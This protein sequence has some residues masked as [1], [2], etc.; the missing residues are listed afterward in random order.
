MAWRSLTLSNG[1]RDGVERDVPERVRDRHADD[2]DLALLDHLV[3]IL[4]R[5]PGRDVGVA[6]LE[7]G[8]ARPGRGDVAGDHPPD[9]RQRPAFPVV[10]AREDGLASGPP[11]L[12]AIGAA[13]GLVVAQ[14]GH[15]PRI[16]GGGILFGER[17]IDDERHHH[18]EIEHQ[19]LVLADE[20]D[21]K[22]LVVDRHEL[23]GLLEAAGR[24][25]EG[26]KAADRHRAVERPFHV[27]GGHRRAVVEGRVLA[28]LE[29]ARHAVRGDLPAFRQLRRQRLAVVGH[30]AVGQR[31]RRVGHQPVVTVPGE[32][33]DG[34]VRADAVHVETVGAELLHQ[35]ENVAAPLRHDRRWA[36][37]R[38]RPCRKRRLQ[39][40]APVEI[41][42]WHVNLPSDHPRPAHRMVRGEFQ[43]RAV[44]ARD[45]APKNSKFR[46]IRAGSDRAPDA[47]RCCGR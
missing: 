30:R 40:C 44:R 20:V 15:R 28:Q 14:P 1:G 46:A 43:T 12:H 38:R 39:E 13:A 26:R 24:H 25:L 3:E 31:L 8:A 32:A 18:R 29:R 27:I 17:G 16:G 36:D 10:E 34:L 23:V 6:A 19:H 35:Q 45:V 41:E 7:H 33:V 11:A 47:R 21:A 42:Q 2:L 4:G 9:L 22:G 37:A 5:K